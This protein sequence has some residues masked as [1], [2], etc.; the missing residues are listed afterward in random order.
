MG[1]ESGV[2][3]VGGGVAGL[4]AATQ[5]ARAGHAVT[6][7]DKAALPRDKVC[8]EGLMPAGL[9]ALAALGLPPATLPGA[10]FHG[11][12]YRGQTRTVPLDFRPGVTGRGVRRTELVGALH[13]LSA[14]TGGVRHVADAIRGPLWEGGAVVGARGVRADYRAPVVLAA[15]GVHAGLARAAGVPL[16]AYGER[17]GLRRHYRLAVEASGSALPRVIV[18]LFAPYDVYLTPVGGRTLLATTMTDRAGYRA[19]T[20]EAGAYDAFLRRSPCG[21]LFDG[22]EPVSARLGWHHPLFT[23]RRYHAGGMLL[24][25]DA[26]GGVDPCLGL[27]VSMALAS[28]AAGARAALGM[29]AA[30]GRRAHWVERYAAERNALFQHTHAFGRVLR[31]A[32]T[33]RRASGVLLAAMQHWPAV[34]E[35]LLDIV[36]RGS[37]WRGFAWSALWEPL[38]RGPTD[39]PDR[40]RAAGCEE[41]QGAQEP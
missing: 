13:A 38:R 22:A 41:T 23:P 36:A 7:V 33:S 15:D 10:P 1:S 31:A 39:R 19:L 16:R 3:I 26:S 4:A 34:A 21:A 35:S 29:L 17:M 2:L 30:P 37:P 6:V 18:G 14:G 24:L 32:I 25:G 27:G 20:A 8:G 5:L 28:A 12:E 9:E 11:L 40:R